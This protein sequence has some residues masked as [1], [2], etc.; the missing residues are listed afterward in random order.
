M[1]VEYL[2]ENKDD[3]YTFYSKILPSMA[4]VSGG[5]WINEER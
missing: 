4:A 1:K 3:A 2:K 5:S